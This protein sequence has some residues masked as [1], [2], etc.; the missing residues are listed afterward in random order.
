MYRPNYLLN[1]LVTNYGSLDSNSKYEGY[2]LDSSINFTTSCQVVRCWEIT[3]FLIEI[4]R[5]LPT[6]WTTCSDCDKKTVENVI[7]AFNGELANGKFNFGLSFWIPIRKEGIKELHWG[8]ANKNEHNSLFD[9]VPPK[10][11]PWISLNSPNSRSKSLGGRSRLIYFSLGKLNSLYKHLVNL[12][13]VTNLF[14]RMNSGILC[15][16]TFHV[17]SE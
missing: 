6:R 17:T 5:L 2:I 7:I 11:I 3:V 15:R 9:N 4:A 14:V 13:Y 10:G 16:S 1:M 12:S 8:I